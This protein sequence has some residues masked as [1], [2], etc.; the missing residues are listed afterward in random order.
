MPAHLYLVRHGETEWTFSSRHTGS[1]D[2]LLTALG[3]DEVRE[4][5]RRL[6]KIPFA[7]VL[8][9]PRKRA[10]RTCEL[11]GLGEGVE[12]EPDLAEWD[13]G[14]FAFRHRPQLTM[15]RQTLYL[16]PE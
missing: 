5:G 6:C 12:I 2:I 14:E 9:S 1:T 3:E 15:P 16:E 10:R 4:W 13:Y 8:T 7:S 11:V